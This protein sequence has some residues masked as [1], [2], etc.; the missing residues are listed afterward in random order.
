MSGDCT[1]CGFPILVKDYKPKTCPFCSTINQP[2]NSGLSIFPILIGA[3][4]LGVLLL[5]QRAK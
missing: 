3:A 4:V 5:T 2:V 1:V